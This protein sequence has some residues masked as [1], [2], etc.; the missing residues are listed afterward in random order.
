LNL[1]QN[2]NCYNHIIDSKLEA[3]PTLGI[4]VYPIIYDPKDQGTLNQSYI[5]KY[6]LFALL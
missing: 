4:F 3:Y 5:D 6:N 1:V 2:N